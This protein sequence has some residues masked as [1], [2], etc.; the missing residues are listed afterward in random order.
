MRT[1][2]NYLAIAGL[3]LGV[4]ISSCKK[5]DHDCGQDPPPPPPSQ[6]CIHTAKATVERCWP[7]TNLWLLNVYS[8]GT[9][10]VS[11]TLA[12]L[13]PQNLPAAFQNNITNVAFEFELLNDSVPYVCGCFGQ[14]G[15]ARK[16]NVCNMRTD[17]MQIVILKPVIYLYPQKTTNVDVELLYDGKLTVTYPEYNTSKKG[18]TV[19]AKPDGT[20]INSDD[21]Q[22]YQ[23]LFWEGVPATPYNFDMNAGYCVKGSDTRKFL[24]NILPKMGLTPKEY[25]DMIVF[26]LPKMQDNAY[27]I[28]HFAG[29]TYTEKAPLHISP[30]PDNLIRVFMAFQPSAT[31]VETKEPVLPAFSRS[32]FTAVEWGGTEMPVYAKKLSL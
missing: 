30:K 14:P 19:K 24:Q 22:E 2:F 15:Y 8:N 16:V 10:P 27:N 11:P 25:N 3:L 23:Y 12:V 31:Y 4:V 9:S 20:L 13:A 28:I 26:W 18:W 32:G 21:N 1:S 6:G 5:E 29:E 17:S 7:D